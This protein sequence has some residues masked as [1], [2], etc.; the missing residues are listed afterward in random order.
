MS[1]TQYECD[2][3]AA[4]T[5]VSTTEAPWEADWIDVGGEG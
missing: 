4:M 1:M 3:V 5:E 2:A